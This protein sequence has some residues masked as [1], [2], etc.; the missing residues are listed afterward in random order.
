MYDNNGNIGD[1]TDDVLYWAELDVAGKAVTNP[2]A[3]TE[4]TGGA[5]L[6]ACDR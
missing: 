3:I 4:P 1:Y 6:C 5:C 2:V